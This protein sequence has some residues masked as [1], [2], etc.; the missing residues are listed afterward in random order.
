MNAIRICPDADCA[1]NERPGGLCAT[2]PNLVM[3]EMGGTELKGSKVRVI[4]TVDEALQEFGV[5]GKS[6]LSAMLPVGEDLVKWIK[7]L[8]NARPTSV[9]ERTALE[10]QAYQQIRDLLRIQNYDGVLAKIRQ[11]IADTEPQIPV[12]RKGLTT[13]PSATVISY[14]P[15]RNHSYP[16]EVYLNGRDEFRLDF[17]WEGP[18]R[19]ITLSERRTRPKIILRIKTGPDFK[20]V[21]WGART[22]FWGGQAPVF[23][24]NTD[25]LVFLTGAGQGFVFVDSPILDIK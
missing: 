23:Q 5:P 17:P 10:A 4:N 20:Y 25:N 8:E 12:V 11:I 22:L 6:P 24:P 9:E 15:M 16:I 14:D 13:Y 3:H 2:C 18:G 1:C 21:R 7:R 19:N